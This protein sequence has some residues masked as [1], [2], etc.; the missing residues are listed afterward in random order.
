MSAVNHENPIQSIS[1]LDRYAPGTGVMVAL[2]S[3]VKARA[4]LTPNVLTQS[5]HPNDIHGLSS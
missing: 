4:G 5:V 2:K 1:I 3:K